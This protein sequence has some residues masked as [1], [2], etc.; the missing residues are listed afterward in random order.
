MTGGCACGAVRFE[1]RRRQRRGLSV[2]L[3]DVPARE[4]QC[5]TR[6][7]EKLRRP[8]S[9]WS[10][11]PDW[12]RSSPIA[13]R[14]LLRRVRHVARLPVSGGHDEDGP[15]RRRVRRSVA[16]PPDRALRRRKHPRGVARHRHAAAH[17]RRRASETGRRAGQAAGEDA[18]DERRRHASLDR[19]GRGRAG[20]PRD[21]AGA[22]RRPA[23]RAVQ[24]RPRQLDQVRPRR[25]ARRRAACASSCPTCAPTGQAPRRTTRPTTP[26][27]SSAATSRSSSRTSASPI[28]TSAVSRSARAP[29][30]RALARGSSRAARCLRAWVSKA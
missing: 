1:A 27:A 6:D 18:D 29:R 11:E 19:V 13:E 26:T 28:T 8:R 25:Q 9:S 3:P 12:Y 16:L 10:R 30:C 17:P 2:P 15:H 20:F 24:Q 7:V 21:G 22:A 4:R 23:P 14:P 5:Q